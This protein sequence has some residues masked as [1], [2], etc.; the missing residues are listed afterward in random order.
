[1]KNPE[2]YNRTVDILVQAY[3]NDTLRHGN[4]SACAVGNIIKANGGFKGF[5]S[6]WAEVFMT[7]E[8]QQGICPENY[9]GD[10]KSEIDSTG[11]AWQDLAKIEK[12]FESAKGIKDEKMFN[13]LMAVIEVLDQIHENTDQ[14]VTKVSK[15]KFVKCQV[16]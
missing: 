13:G 2:L 8:G 7:V 5:F 12:S 10:A 16:V 1:M 6:N 9:E 15:Q 3:F 14:E 11:Y 4:C